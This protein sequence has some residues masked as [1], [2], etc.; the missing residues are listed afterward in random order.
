[1]PAGRRP[2]PCCTHNTP[3]YVEDG[4]MGSL[5][6]PHPH[7]RARRRILAMAVA[8]K[9]A[10]VLSTRAPLPFHLRPMRSFTRPATRSAICSRVCFPVFWKCSRCPR[11]HSPGSGLGLAAGFLA[12]DACAIPGA[13][14]E[15]GFGFELGS[16]ILTWLGVGSFCTRP[17]RG[18]VELTALVDT[19]CRRAWHAGSRRG[20]R[21]HGIRR[22]HIGPLLTDNTTSPLKPNFPKACEGFG[23]SYW[24]STLPCASRMRIFAGPISI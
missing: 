7:P 20:A 12:G 11:R 1:M 9:A 19:A 6:R 5:P 3:Q 18:S 10:G 15:A 22:P 23:R 13:A 8:W 4:T 17:A 14:A 2:G 24:S 21:E 16:A